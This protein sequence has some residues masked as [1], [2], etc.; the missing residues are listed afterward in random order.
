MLKKEKVCLCNIVCQEDIFKLKK[1]PLIIWHCNAP[2]HFI[3]IYISPDAAS[4]NVPPTSEPPSTTGE[5]EQGTTLTVGGQQSQEDQISKSS[6]EN[7]PI[8]EEQKEETEVAAASAGQDTQQPGGEEEKEKREEQ[9]SVTTEEEQEM[10]TS[11][12]ANP[13]CPEGAI[14]HLLFPLTPNLQFYHL[15]Q[16]LVRWHLF[17]WLQ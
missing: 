15:L 16:G 4:T 10:D 6:E 8:P 12:D 7:T 9:G 2:I 11:A 17:P 1:S 13:T 3:L 5:Q 14:R